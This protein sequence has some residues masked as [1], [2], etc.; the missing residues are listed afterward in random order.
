MFNHISDNRKTNESPAPRHINDADNICFGA[1]ENMILYHTEYIP[2]QGNGQRNKSF[3]LKTELYGIKMLGTQFPHGM[4]D[5]II[6]K[7]EI[8]ITFPFCSTARKAFKITKN[9]YAKL[10]TLYPN[11]FKAKL[12]CPFKRNKNLIT[13]FLL[14][15]S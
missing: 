13:L 10:Q 12:M 1:E 3:R 11:V 7:R 14:H 2:D 6:R 15:V 4:N 9:T 5:R 8:F